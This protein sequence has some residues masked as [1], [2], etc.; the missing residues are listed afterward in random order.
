ME[1]AEHG[2]NVSASSSVA[3]CAR[4]EYVRFIRSDWNVG[5]ATL[6]KL[7]AGTAHSKPYERM[8]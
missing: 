4:L 5:E 8:I 7:G 6:T 1:I 3:G 2:A